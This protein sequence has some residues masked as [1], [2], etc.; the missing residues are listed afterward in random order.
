MLIAKAYWQ[1]AP[2]RF[3]EAPDHAA[4]EPLILKAADFRELDALLWKPKGESRVA[5]VAMHPRVDFTRHYCFPALLG[6]GVTCLGANTRNPNN[7]LDT[8]H[9][10]IA[11]DLA[12]CMVELRRRDFET[13]ILLGNSGGGSLSALYQAEALRAPDQRTARDPSGMPTA[14][15][16]AE[17]PPADGTI[18]IAPHPGQGRILEGCIDPSVVDEADPRSVDA[19]LDMYAEANGFREPPTWSRYDDAFVARFRDA[20]RARVQRLDTHARELIARQ[21]EGHRAT[22]APGFDALPLAERRTHLLDKHTDHVLTIYRTMANP[23]Y[24][25]DHLDPSNRDYGS[26]IS[27][28]PDLMNAKLFGFARVCTPRAW[29][30]TWSGQSSNADMLKN[31]PAIDTPTLFVSAGADRE[32]HPRSHTLPMVEAIAAEDRTVIDLPE[33]EHYFQSHREELTQHIVGWIEERFT[34]R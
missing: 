20:Q 14:L 11:L 27:D 33:A 25:D 23:C 29:L 18:Y 22:K 32:I 8:V 4:V 12:A 19:E 10:H 21:R 28:R 26:L 6:A 9:E 1:G 15:P 30:S 34:I 16:R 31:L 24:V 5:V 17:M 13:V 7:D 3:R 2:F